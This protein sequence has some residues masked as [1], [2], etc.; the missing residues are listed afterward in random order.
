[1]ETTIEP[2]LLLTDEEHIQQYN[3]QFTVRFVNQKNLYQEAKDDLILNLL[4]IDQLL[5]ENGALQKSCKDHNRE[6]AVRGH[7]R[8]A[9]HLQKS[10][11]KEN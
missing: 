1:M 7:T 3:T 10:E 8:E 2:V 6:R 9:W 11:P 5:T 4:K